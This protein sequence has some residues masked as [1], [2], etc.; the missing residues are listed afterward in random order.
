M[1]SL[2]VGCR[3]NFRGKQV[4]TEHMLSLLP[5][6]LKHWLK[7]PIPTLFHFPDA[8]RE[9]ILYQGLIK[10]ISLTFCADCIFYNPKTTLLCF[11]ESK[12]KVYWLTGNVLFFCKQ[13]PKNRMN[14]ALSY[15][16][17][18]KH[19]KHFKTCWKKHH[20]VQNLYYLWHV[21]ARNIYIGI[22]WSMVGEGT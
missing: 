19:R 18:R 10:D 4:F 22:T 15:N 7:H 14:L 8:I 16:Q 9:A 21:S 17:I 12:P 6:H 20:Y 3:S 11:T 5:R 2:S 13:C 1:T